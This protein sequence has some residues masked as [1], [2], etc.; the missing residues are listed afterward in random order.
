MPKIASAL[1]RP[2]TGLAAAIVNTMPERPDLGKTRGD[3]QRSAL[4]ELG[5]PE[6]SPKLNAILKKAVAPEQAAVLEKEV[7]TL[8]SNGSFA[9]RATFERVASKELKI[10]LSSPAVGKDLSVV[11]G[12]DLNASMFD[13]KVKGDGSIKVPVALKE[14]MKID[15]GGLEPII[16][17]M[18]PA[19]GDSLPFK[20]EE[21]TP[22]QGAALS[23][24]KELELSRK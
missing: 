14:D 16:I 4:Q 22:K 10:A 9:D 15:F 11:S 3:V 18:A 20:A 8:R 2:E 1:K 13:F 23:L 19:T 12:I 6:N 5:R 24:S 21:A 17:K 7:Q